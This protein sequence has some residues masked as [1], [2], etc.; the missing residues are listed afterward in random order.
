MQ[1]PHINWIKMGD[2]AICGG[3]CDDRVEFSDVL[4]VEHSEVVDGHLYE[5]EYRLYDLY[6]E[7]FQVR[8]EGDPR[9][10]E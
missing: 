10:E 7:K 3:D 5:K 4:W 8:H 6:F 1:K 9:K 2:F